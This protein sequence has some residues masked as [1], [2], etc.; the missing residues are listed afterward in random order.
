MLSAKQSSMSVSEQ[1]FL[2]AEDTGNASHLNAAHG[3][4]AHSVYIA[5][6]PWIGSVVALL[7]FPQ[8]VVFQRALGWTAALAFWE[9]MQG[10][11]ESTYYV[12]YQFLGPGVWAVPSVFAFLRPAKLN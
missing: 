4:P 11:L 3:I 6:S 12:G 9:P 5:Q 8:A 2:M 7:L 1:G 10:T